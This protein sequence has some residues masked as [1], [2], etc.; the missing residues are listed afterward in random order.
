MNL[1][2]FLKKVVAELKES[3]ARYALA[4]GI[5]ASTYR[6]IERITKDVDFLL[7]ASGNTSEEASRIIK[8]F[9]LDVHVIKKS[10]LERTPGFSKKNSPPFIIAGRPEK[11]SHRIGLDF[12]MPEMPWFKN[13]MDR[14]QENKIDFGFDKI[15]SMTVEDIIISKLYALYNDSSRFNDLD[16]LKSIFGAGHDLDLSYIS[17]Q[18]LKLKLAIPLSLKDFAPSALL[19]V[20]KLVR[21]NL[22]KK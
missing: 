5:V 19:K 6:S 20:S 7:L 9:D 8:K 21:R 16:D 22:S 1:T 14:A 12:I 13:A 4:G 2:D 15:P 17:G 11:D 18:M 10:D 3:N